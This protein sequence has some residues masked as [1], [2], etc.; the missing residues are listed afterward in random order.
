MM[1]DGGAAAAAPLSWPQAGKDRIAARYDTFA[2][3][4][5]HERIA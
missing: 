4:R 2:E 1:P 5:V 3:A